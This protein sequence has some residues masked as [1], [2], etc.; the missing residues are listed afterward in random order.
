M[1]PVQWFVVAFCGWILREQDDAIAL[2]REE[3]RVWR[4]QLRGRPLPLSDE[5]RRRLAVLG[6]QLGRAA[7]AQVATIATADTVLGWH[8]E[9]PAHRCAPSRR[10]TGRPRL[11][12]GVRSLIRRMAVEN[13]TWGYRR[14]QGALPNL[15]HGVGRST[16]ARIL[17]EQGIPPS[18]RRPIAWRTFIAGPLAC[19]ARRRLLDE[20]GRASPRLGHPLHGVG[21][22]AEGTADA[23]TPRH[24]CRPTA[25]CV[26]C[27]C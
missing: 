21:P 26:R 25:F 9:L 24:G 5:E 2:L 13:A 10:R 17:R 8:R 18:G 22:R 6:H 23:R 11:E 15:G 14:I 27:G 20:P 19:A 1:L 12:G 16:I 7:L 4:A 3:N